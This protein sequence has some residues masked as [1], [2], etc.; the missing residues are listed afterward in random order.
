M[1]ISIGLPIPLSISSPVIIVKRSVEDSL[2]IEN[3]KA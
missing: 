2:S 3:S 1:G